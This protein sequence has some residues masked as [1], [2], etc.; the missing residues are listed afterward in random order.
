MFFSANLLDNTEEPWER[1]AKALPT[2]KKVSIKVKFKFKICTAPPYVLRFKIASEM[3]GG[4]DKLEL[5][6]CWI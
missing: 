6:P 4:R 1:K 2:R 5:T 3:F